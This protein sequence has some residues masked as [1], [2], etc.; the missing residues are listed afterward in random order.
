MSTPS[1]S[2][3]PLSA[4]ARP[5]ESDIWSEI[6]ELETENMKALENLSNDYRLTAESQG[7][8]RFML[9]CSRDIAADCR[10]IALG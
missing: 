7:D 9:V 4:S 6:A 8:V 3:T 2:T 5:Q 10:Q 1:V